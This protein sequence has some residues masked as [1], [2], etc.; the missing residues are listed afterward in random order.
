VTFDKEFHSKLL[1]AMR[2]YA[3]YQVER[4]NKKLIQRADKL[5]EELYQLAVKNVE[6]QY[7]VKLNK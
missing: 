1:K 3:S 6:F 4:E 2:Q 7:G 5:Y